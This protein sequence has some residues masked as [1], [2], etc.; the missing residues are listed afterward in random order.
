MSGPAGAAAP[1]NTTVPHPSSNAT[2]WSDDADTCLSE[3]EYAARYGV[4]PT[5]VQLLATCTDLTYETPPQIAQ[6]NEHL[7]QQLEPGDESTSVAPST[8]TLRSSGQLRDVHVSVVGLSPSTVVHRSGNETER[9]VRP[10]GTLYG[11]VDYRV[12]TQPTTT[13]NTTVSWRV[14]DHG[15]ESVS[16]SDPRGERATTAGTQQPQFAYR[17]LSMG[18]TQLTVTATVTARLEKTVTHSTNYSTH[19]TTQVVTNSIT[20]TDTV[21]VTVTSPT[22]T[23]AT[24][25]FPDG[26]QRV[27]LSQASPW[28]RYD[29]VGRAGENETAGVQNVWQ[30]YTAGDAAWQT[31]VSRTATTTEHYATPHQPLV[32]HALPTAPAPQSLSSPRRVR[33]LNTT[34]SQVDN[35]PM[36]DSN[37]SIAASPYRQVTHLRVQQPPAT[38]IRLSGIVAGNSTTVPLPLDPPVAHNPHLALEVVSQ[39]ATSATLRV[40]LR[41][42]QT[43]AA[44]NVSSNSSTNATGV[45][46]VDG[47]VVSLGENGTATVALSEPGIHRATF[48]PAPWQPGHRAYTRATAT[49]GWHPLTTPAGLTAASWDL[50][51]LAIPVVVVLYAIRQLGG[52]FTSNP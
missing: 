39:S 44:L 40:T 6:V 31:L 51:Q 1:S 3:D 45:L 37:V 43:G 25:A 8:A 30:F 38:A 4:A 28:S 33:V 36:V 11:F 27:F 48:S 23:V 49:V 52:L 16:L 26:S 7:I 21:P 47:T 10:N 2:W 42:A 46:T 14:I 17:N 22:A 18:A 5:T 19:T 13:E 9:Y 15:V 41:D 35:P 29:V 34:G 50:L 32:V 20:V 24:V 12:E